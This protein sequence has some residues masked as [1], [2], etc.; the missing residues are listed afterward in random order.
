MIYNVDYISYNCKKQIKYV[1]LSLQKIKS[2][3]LI[4]MKNQEVK[5]VLKPDKTEKIKNHFL[6]IIG[7][8]IY[9]KIT[10]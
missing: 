6:T 5:T 4:N 2:I 10:K 7:V 9:I 8:H 1:F 3:A